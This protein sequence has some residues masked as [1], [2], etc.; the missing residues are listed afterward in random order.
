MVNGGVIGRSSLAP[1]GNTLW[2]SALEFVRR[3][4]PEDQHHSFA[5]CLNRNTRYRY[6]ERR[7]C[8]EGIAR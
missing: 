4:R 2:G 5:R 6:R 3:C 1:D 7:E 8:R